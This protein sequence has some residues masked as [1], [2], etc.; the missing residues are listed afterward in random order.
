MFGERTPALVHTKKNIERLGK[1]VKYMNENKLMGKE[2]IL[3]GSLPR[4][5]AGAGSASV[6]R[7][8]CGVD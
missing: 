3:R 4:C 8:I 5:G 1:L 2:E 6:R 7:S